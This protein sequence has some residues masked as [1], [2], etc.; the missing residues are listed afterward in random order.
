MRHL[1]PRLALAVPPTL[2][3]RYCVLLDAIPLYFYC[4][5]G[6]YNLIDL[7]SCFPFRRTKRAV[8]LNRSLESQTLI[9]TY[10]YF[11]IPV[12]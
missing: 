6:E 12:G 3:V 4:L 5:I 8:L 1:L 7:F 2:D 10:F 9:K 11:L